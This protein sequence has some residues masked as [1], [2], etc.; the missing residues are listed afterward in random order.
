MYLNCH[1]SLS[2][3]YGTLTPEELLAE[4]QRCGVTKL[5]V[6]EINNTASYVELMR[7]VRQGRRD[8]GNAA[9]NAASK[10]DAAAPDIA[11]GIEFRR[12]GQLL[13]VG[14]AKNNAGFEEL[15]RF[16]SFHNRDGRRL[17][18]LAPPFVNCIVIYPY[19]KIEPEKLREN[20]FI[21]VRLSEI[22]ALTIDQSYRSHKTKFVLLQPVTF[23]DKIQYNIHRLLRAIDKNTLLSKLP[24]H[25]QADPD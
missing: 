20:E 9:P 13:Y 6:T 3:R 2:F 5:V 14:I 17:P 12:D 11:V 4:A 23:K 10:G 16:L 19:R 1:T 18:T 7:I 22:G 24:T 25:E 21:G 15:N 8:K